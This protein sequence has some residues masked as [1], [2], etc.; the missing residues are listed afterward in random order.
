MAVEHGIPQYF[1]TFTANEMGWS[2]LK[3]ACEGEAFSSCAMDATR[4]Y[5]HR[6]N[7]FLKHYLSPGTKS[8]IGKID[9]I[10]W[11]HEDQGRGSLHV[12]AAIWVTPDSF[13][14]GKANIAGT[15]PRCCKTPEEKEWRRFVLNVQR[16][17]CRPKC[18][19]H[20]GEQ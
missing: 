7:N 2:D 6:W 19:M 3:S 11:R 18:R 20:A 12:H 8:P 16:H 14:K 17:D 9:R 4:V 5:N 15:A 1:V 10:W 13:D